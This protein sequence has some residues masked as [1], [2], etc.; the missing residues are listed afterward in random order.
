MHSDYHVL[1]LLC[2]QSKI[3]DIYDALK[4]DL[5]HNYEALGRPAILH[6]AMRLARP[7]AQLIVPLEYGSSLE[8]MVRQAAMQAMLSRMRKRAFRKTRALPH[9][10]C[11]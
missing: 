2:V 1:C 5:R 7:L 11:R 9:L 8:D 10:P 6:D 3:P 4:F